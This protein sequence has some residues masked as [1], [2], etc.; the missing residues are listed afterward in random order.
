MMMMMRTCSS[1]SRSSL[2]PASR[3][4][5]HQRLARGDNDDDDD[6]DDDHDDDDYDD[7]DDVDDDDGDNAHLAGGRSRRRGCAR[8][9][10]PP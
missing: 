7:D 9:A 6:D 5:D 4:L 3:G 1:T 8:C 2:T 10:R